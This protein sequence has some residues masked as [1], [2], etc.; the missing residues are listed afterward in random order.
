MVFSF[1]HRSTDYFARPQDGLWKSATIWLDKQALD[2]YSRAKA[3][4]GFSDELASRI[5]GWLSKNR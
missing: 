2:L 1:A 3:H 4:F 5:L